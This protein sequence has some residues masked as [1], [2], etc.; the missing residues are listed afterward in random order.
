MIFELLRLSIDI[1]D[2]DFNEIYPEHIRALARK[3]WTPVAVAKTASEFL[4][5]RRGTRVLDIGSGAGKFCMIGAANTKGHFTGIEQRPE[6]VEL[7]KKLSASYGLPNTDFIH[8]NVTSIRFRDYDAFYL[9]NPFQ[10]N[11]DVRHR[12]DETVRLSTELYDAYSIH[13]IN[14]LST[15]PSGARLATYWT[16][17]AVVPANFKLVDTLYK[18]NLNLWEKW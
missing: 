6:L 1:T 7:S 11:I 8:A 13:T 10:E 5:A 3:H 4:V 9:Y 12:I 14:Q 16:P 18:G 2:E 17:S 15:L